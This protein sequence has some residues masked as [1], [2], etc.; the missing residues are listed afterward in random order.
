MNVFIRH[1]GKQYPDLAELIKQAH[2]GDIQLTGSVFVR[3]GNLLARLLCKLLNMPKAGESVQLVVHGSHT[4]HEMRWSRTFDG[5]VMQSCFKEHGPYLVEKM[6]PISL[7]M[8]LRVADGALEYKLIRARFWG[9][10]LPAF[11]A[12]KLKAC[13][14]EKTS[15]YDF[16]VRIDL[17]VIGKLI[18]YGG[19]LKLSP[20][21]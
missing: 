8:Q 14:M 2:I 7:W 10:P 11:L 4:D 12:P 21:G 16:A 3:Q 9:L 13:E 19:I 18:E 5:H 6:G 1:L 17:P 20:L 15:G